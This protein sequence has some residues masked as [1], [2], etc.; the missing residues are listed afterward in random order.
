MRTIISLI[1]VMIRIDYKRVNFF[2]NLS[3]DV[4]EIYGFNAFFSLKYLLY[5]AEFTLVF[6]IK[7]KY[8]FGFL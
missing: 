7:L 3:A 5:I 4:V 2:D 6:S 8:L 1:E